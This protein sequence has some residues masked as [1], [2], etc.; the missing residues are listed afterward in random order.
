MEIGIFE[1][2][3]EI[4]VT[5]LRSAEENNAIAS[6]EAARKAE[7]ARIEKEREEQKAVEKTAELLAIIV[8]QIN[9]AAEK[10]AFSV[11]FDWTE[12]VPTSNSVQW[13][14]WEKY[15]NRFIPVL[16]KMG[17]K[18]YTHL[19]SQSWRYQSGRICY[20]SIHW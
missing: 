5:C 14:D 20:V 1:K 13:K 19:Y 9:I 6:V 4:T 12:Q 15:S 18:C 8:E 16:E 7:I 3:G 2:V 17:Y 10:G 11:N